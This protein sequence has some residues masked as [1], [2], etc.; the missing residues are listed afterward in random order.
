MKRLLYIGVLHGILGQDFLVFIKVARDC[1]SSDVGSQADPRDD[2]AEIAGWVKRSW[3]RGKVRF[4]VMYNTNGY[5]KLIDSHRL[6]LPFELKHL[7]S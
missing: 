3:L 6:V 4:L 1:L 7:D 5:P 2:A